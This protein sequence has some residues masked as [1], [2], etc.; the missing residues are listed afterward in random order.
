MIRVNGHK[1]AVWKT[2][3]ASEA[4]F[5]RE[6]KAVLG[7]G[8]SW[9]EDDRTA[10]R[11]ILLVLLATQLTVGVPLTDSALRNKSYSILL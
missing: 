4:S 7:D 8:V 10:V 5:H 3:T 11:H 9:W 1:L 2:T 6:S